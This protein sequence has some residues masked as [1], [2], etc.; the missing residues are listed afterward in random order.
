MPNIFV[1]DLFVNSYVFA[2]NLGAASLTELPTDSA[3]GCS[4]IGKSVRQST[5]SLKK[6]AFRVVWPF[7]PTIRIISILKCL[8]KVQHR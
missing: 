2:E 5:D 1:E 6:K 7:G 3:G 8:W 4:E